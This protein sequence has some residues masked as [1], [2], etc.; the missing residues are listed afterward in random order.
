MC[1]TYKC[2]YLINSGTKREPFSGKNNNNK[3]NNYTTKF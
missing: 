3:A 2:V 1:V